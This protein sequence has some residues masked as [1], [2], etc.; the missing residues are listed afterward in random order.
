MAR[1]IPELGLDHYTTA[2]LIRAREFYAQIAAN[3]HA[4]LMCQQIDHELA[5]RL[6]Y[7]QTDDDIKKGK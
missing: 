5:N 2:E 7:V 4:V 6:D 1:K 3:T